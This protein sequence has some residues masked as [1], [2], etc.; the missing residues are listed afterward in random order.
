ML[1]EQELQRSKMASI[2][3]QM[4]PHF[5]FNALNTI[6]SFIYTNEKSLAVSYLNQF[7]ELTRMILDMSNLDLISLMD[8][9]KALRLYLDLETQRFEEKL[10]YEIWIDPE[11]QPDFFLLPPMLVQPYVEN[12]IKH[13]L[14]HSKL[15]WQ[16]SIAFRKTINGLEVAV[17]DNG[18]G[19]KKSGQLNANRQ[20]HHQ[21]F[22]MKANKKRLEIL[23]KG[24]DNDIS[25]EIIDKE[26]EWGA[27]SGTR[28]ILRVPGNLKKGM[29]E[30]N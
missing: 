1:L 24:L 13:G 20:K 16:L 22:A 9:I 15:P 6:Q 18:I 4:N 7:S 2:K 28:V 21:S 26:N 14:L 19:R 30:S 23:N 17:E 10:Q 5:F 12:A 27:A 8:E 29:G 25:V 11:L 3:S